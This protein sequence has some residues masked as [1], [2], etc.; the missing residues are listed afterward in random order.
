[1]SNT[2]HYAVIGHPIGQ[3]LSPKIHTY[4][5]AQHDID[6]TYEAIAVAPEDFDQNVSG[7][8]ETLDGMNV[9]IPHKTN[10]M[11]YC[12]SLDQTA[13]KV[14]AINC[15][16]KT[17]EGFFEG[18]NTDAYGVQKSLDH[19]IGKDNDKKALVI[20]A[21]G[22]APAVLFALRDRGIKNIVL[23]NRTRDKAARLA[24]KFEGVKVIDWEDK[25]KAATQSGLIINATSLGMDGFPPLAL[26]PQA[27]HGSAAY[28]DII[29]KPAET[30]FLRQ[31]QAAGGKILNGLPMLLY[32]AQKSFKLWTGIEPAVDEVLYQHLG[33]KAP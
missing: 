2:K 26:A 31:A 14:G 15:L 20:G 13:L 18:H 25:N 21:G 23:S 19:L 7:I 9:T 30:E 5:A 29:Y 28:L 11:R 10:I 33:F 3:S 22:A 17:E 12:E 1:M 27:Y 6:L 24:K 8:L 16:V 4:W 32:Q